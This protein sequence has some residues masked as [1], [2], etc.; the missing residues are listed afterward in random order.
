MPI[1]TRTGVNLSEDA[2]G[3]TAPGVAAR[4]GKAVSVQGGEHFFDNVQEARAPPAAQ[5][6]SRPAC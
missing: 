5:K 1:A 3:T 2:V 6:R 4:T